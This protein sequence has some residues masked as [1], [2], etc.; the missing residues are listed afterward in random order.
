MAKEIQLTKSLHFFIYVIVMVLLIGLAVLLYNLQGVN[1][2]S[3]KAINIESTQKNIAGKAI[4]TFECLSNQDCADGK[5]C[6]GGFCEGTNS[7]D[8]VSGQA[9]GPFSDL[10]CVT[11]DDCFPDEQCMDSMCIFVG[12]VCV[13][14]C[15]SNQECVDGMCFDIIDDFEDYGDNNDYVSAEGD[16]LGQN[17]VNDYV[18]S[19][20]NTIPN[21]NQ[22]IQQ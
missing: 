2:T 8:D 20:Q 9:T 7:M 4:A 1:D 6:K 5:K 19:N 18:A 10:S 16:V 12:E 3:G 21:N 13:P 17:N 15:A 14:D 22:V 11:N